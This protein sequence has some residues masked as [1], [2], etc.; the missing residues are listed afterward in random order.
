MIGCFLVC[1]QW[2]F[3]GACSAACHYHGRQTNHQQRAGDCHTVST[4][5]RYFVTVL[6]IN[7]V[8]DAAILDCN[9]MLDR[10]RVGA[11][12]I[13]KSLTRHATPAHLGNFHTPQNSSVTK[14]N[15]VAKYEIVRTH[16]LCQQCRLVRYPQLPGYSENECVYGQYNTWLSFKLLVYDKG[17]RRVKQ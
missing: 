10:Q 15:M 17:L 6:S 11:K 1:A 8:F 4:S 12:S 14:S 7:Q 16:K 2:L 3:N 13:K 9:W 5:L